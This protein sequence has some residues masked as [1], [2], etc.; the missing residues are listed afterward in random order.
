MCSSRSRH[1]LAP[2]LLV[3]RVNPMEGIYIKIN[4]KKPGEDNVVQPVSMEFCQ[5]CQIGI[6]TPEA[7][8]RLI[9]DAARGESTYFTRWDEVAQAWAYV[10]RIA[11]AWR[12]IIPACSFIRQDHGDQKRTDELLAQDGFHWWPVNGQEEDNVIWLIWR[13][14]VTK[15]LHAGSP[16][17]SMIR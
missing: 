4:A 5:S 16:A 2:N 11:A 9:H 6:N 14:K 1:D 10:D 8:E 17:P 13:R 15:L 3:I 7:Y 12:E